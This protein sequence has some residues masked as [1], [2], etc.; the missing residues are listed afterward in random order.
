MRVR[1]F[2]RLCRFVDRDLSETGRI[3]AGA[4]SLLVGLIIVSPLLFYDSPYGGAAALTVAASVVLS[5]TWFAFVGWRGLRLF[6]AM[7]AKADRRF[8]RNTKFSLPSEY[9]ETVS[10]TEASRRKRRLRD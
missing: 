6:R 3:R 7:A 1:T 10:A 5:L 9:R 8:D 4:R 2:H